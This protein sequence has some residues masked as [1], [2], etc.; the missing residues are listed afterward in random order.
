VFGFFEIGSHANELF[1]QA[2]SNL[3][4]PDLYLLSS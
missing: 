4:P 2:A 1:A 3:N